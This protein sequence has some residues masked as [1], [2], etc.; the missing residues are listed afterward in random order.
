MIK[1]WYLNV[2]SK[3]ET[4]VKDFIQAIYNTPFYPAAINKFK[5]AVRKRM[6][7]K[8]KVY[9]NSRPARTRNG[10]DKF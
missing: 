10:T 3:S 6:N 2:G 4:P 1:N 7:F 9:L 5:A 8:N